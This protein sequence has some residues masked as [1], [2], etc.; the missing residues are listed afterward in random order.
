MRRDFANFLMIMFLKFFSRVKINYRAQINYNVFKY[1][2]FNNKKNINIRKAILSSGIAL[3]EGVQFFSSPEIFGNVSIGRYTSICGPATRICANLNQVV[4]G[5]FCSIASNVIIQEHYHKIDAVTTSSIFNNFFKKKELS[6][7]CES[8]GDIIIEDDVWIGSNV[9][10]LSGVRIG[11]GSIIGAGS[12]VTKNVEPYSIIGG[13]PFRVIRK[14]FDENRINQL[15]SSK[16]WLW[17]R[18][19]IL[20]NEIFFLDDN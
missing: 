14:R 20:K 5:N 9:C 16:W 1:L 2:L 17:S 7:S 15:E 10:I 11:R 19:E 18:E 3:D 4:I 12:V 8:R 13:N 6:L